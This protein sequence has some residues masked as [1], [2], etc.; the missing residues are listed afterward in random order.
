MNSQYYSADFSQANPDYKLENYSFHIT[1]MDGN[2]GMRGDLAGW[3][4]RS[5]KDAA[6]SPGWSVNRRGFSGAFT[7]ASAS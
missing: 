7:I 6:I 2:I 3:P 5:G 4:A 1:G